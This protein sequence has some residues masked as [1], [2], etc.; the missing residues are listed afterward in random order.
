MW[1][2]WYSD[3]NGVLMVAEIISNLA[4][5]DD[6]D[7]VKVA[8]AL[9]DKSTY[10][11]TSQIVGV[12]HAYVCPNRKLVWVEGIRINSKYRRMG[13]ASELIDRMIEYGREMDNNIREA[14]AITAETNIASRQMLEKNEFQK[15]AKWIYYTGHKENG[16]R[17]NIAS[18]RIRKNI[19]ENNQGKVSN[20]D[21]ANTRRRNM[22]VS[23][24][25]VSDIGEI[26]TFLS[27]SKT[28]ISSGRRYVQSWKWY[29]LKLENSIISELITNKKI[30]IVRTKGIW[31]IR[32]LAITNNHVREKYR[33]ERLQS[34]DEGLRQ[35]SSEKDD[36]GY[37]DD[38]DASFQIVYLDAPTSTYLEDL[39][40]FTV[41]RVIS[42]GKFDRI[43]LFMPNQMHDEKTDFSE[44]TD[45]LARFDISKSE[46]FLLYVRSI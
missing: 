32:A 46:K 22:V 5:L 40:L 41:N 14:A 7:V 25:S 6:A 2:T 9:D 37:N 17:T 23:F 18:L 4:D 27:K 20:D 19:F 29:E 36:S 21:D 12:S 3:L 34:G 33:A 1:D 13:I 42:S 35:I 45:V 28:F 44:I 26:I 11:K 16:N 30:I 8:P 10:S 31:G 24:A 15:R 38:D 39:L 43:Q